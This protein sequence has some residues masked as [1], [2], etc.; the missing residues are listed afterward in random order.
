MSPL[1]PS[2]GNCHANCI[3]RS[4]YGCLT[5]MET[6]PLLHY[7]MASE[8]HLCYS[9]SLSDRLGCLFSSRVFTRHFLMG[10]YLYLSRA[11]GSLRNPRPIAISMALHRQSSHSGPSRAIPVAFSGSVSVHPI[12][13][14]EEGPL[15]F[16]PSVAHLSQLLQGRFHALRGTLRKRGSSNLI[17]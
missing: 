5:A 10:S 2:S 11:F 4:R 16:L 12:I 14:A 3:S 17:V 1:A 9:M 7:H 6:C 15:R 13:I 8:L